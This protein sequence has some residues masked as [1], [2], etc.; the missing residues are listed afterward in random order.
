MRQERVTAMQRRTGPCGGHSSGGHGRRRGV[1][2][3]WMALFLFVLLGIVGLSLDWGKKYF[4]LHQLHNAADAAA[5]A[6]AQFVKFD[7]A[8]ARRQAIA[9]AHENDTDRVSVSLRD[10]PDND[11]DGDVVV[12]WWDKLSRTFTPRTRNPNA[13]QVLANRTAD[14]PDG[15]VSLNFAVMAGIGTTEISR[16]AV[17]RSVGATGAG[18]IAL[19]KTGTGLLVSGN[20]I[21]DVM[22]GDIQVDSYERQGMRVNGDAAFVDC[23]WVRVCG[24]ARFNPPRDFEQE[25][26]DILIGAR[27]D[28]VNYV[29]DPLL[30]LPEPNYASWPDLSPSPNEP[31]TDSRPDGLPFEAGYYSGGFRFTASGVN[32]VFKPGVYVVGGEGLY[33]NGGNL[34]AIG[35]TFYIAQGPLYL[36]GSGTLTLSPPG[37]TDPPPAF[38]YPDWQEPWW[39]DR[40]YNDISIFQARDNHN[41]ST[42]IGT[43]GYSIEGGLYFPENHIEIQ[44]TAGTTFRP[45]N[46]LIADTIEISGNGTIQIEYDGRNLVEGFRS[47]LVK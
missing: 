5:L 41:D 22:G 7:H 27:G 23:D 47:V 37:S 15:P 39:T 14:S 24:D 10:N 45:G 43:A 38:P 18:L 6:G 3:V 4:N 44:G 42:I 16:T 25:P 28:D 26:Y 19:S 21:L 13:V 29:P 17:A 12:G 8:A 35:V 31:Y 9:I 1:A 32:A 40:T 33:M 34:T 30:S 11:P 2:L 46:Q 20:P 36:G